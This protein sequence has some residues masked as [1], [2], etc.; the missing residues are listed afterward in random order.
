MR[1]ARVE[2]SSSCSSSHIGASAARV[3]I[4]ST[5]DK[6]SWRWSVSNC[7]V[8]LPFFEVQLGQGQRR[9]VRLR[10]REVLDEGPRLIEASRP[11]QYASEG[12]D[13]DLGGSALRAQV[14]GAA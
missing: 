3:P 4:D 5:S 7:G 9:Q 14:D 8:L 13:V 12:Q 1:P 6:S 10:R 11:L 2:I